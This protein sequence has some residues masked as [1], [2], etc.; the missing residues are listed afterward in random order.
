MQDI[1]LDEIAKMI[2]DAVLAQ[3]Y[4]NRDKLQTLIRPIL[5]IWLKSTDEFKSQKATK[6]KLQFTIENREIQQKFW[7]SKVRE[8]VGNEN[9]QPFYDELDYILTEQGYK[10]KT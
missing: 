8:L 6:T 3:P 2:T 9:M 4:I 1:S 10:S 5:K 7:L